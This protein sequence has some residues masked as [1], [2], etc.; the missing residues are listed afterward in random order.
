M[1]DAMGWV[2]WLLGHG[3]GDMALGSIFESFIRPRSCMIT[4]P[5]IPISHYSIRDGQAYCTSVTFLFSFGYCR[6]FD[7]HSKDYVIFIG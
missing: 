1:D 5:H 7:H 3:M 2:T 4:A 6:Q